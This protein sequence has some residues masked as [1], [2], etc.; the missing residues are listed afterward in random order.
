MKYMGSKNRHFKRLSNFI[1]K[2]L[3]NF[4]FFVEPFC[5]GCNFIDKVEGVKRIA[6]DSNKYL[7]AFLNELVNNPDNIPRNVT[8]NEYK[9]IKDLE[10]K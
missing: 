9:N 8:R 3:E 1:L 10:I 6:S 2:D 7:I 4:D 5:G